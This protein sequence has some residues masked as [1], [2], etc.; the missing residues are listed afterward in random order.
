[1]L[2]FGSSCLDSCFD[3]GGGNPSWTA[4]ATRLLGWPQTLLLDQDPE[5]ITQH[6]TELL[7]KRPSSLSLGNTDDTT[8]CQN[9][10]V[11]VVVEDEE[12]TLYYFDAVAEPLGEDEFPVVETERSVGFCAPQKE[13]CPD[14]NTIIEPEQQTN[15]DRIM[16][17]LEK[18]K[19]LLSSAGYPGSL[20]SNELRECVSMVLSWNNVFERM[21]H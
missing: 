3:S 1:M 13:A 17:A 4:N 20:T 18:P 11:E 8:K 14:D 16:K 6:L 21:C 7:P 10:E 2:F 9:H 19:V 15:V 12:D 5:T